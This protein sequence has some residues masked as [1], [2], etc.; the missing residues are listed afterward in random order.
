LPAALSSS[1]QDIGPQT[2]EKFHFAYDIGLTDHCV[3][4][5]SVSDCDIYVG[6]R[7]SKKVEKH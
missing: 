6:F 5:G 4:W 3:S 1:F 2:L 7:C